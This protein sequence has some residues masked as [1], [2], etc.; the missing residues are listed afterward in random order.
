M[1]TWSSDW[2]RVII[3]VVITHQ[4]LLAVPKCHQAV[5]HSFICGAKSSPERLSFI[6]LLNSRI[7]KP[8]KTSKLQM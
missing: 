8:T 4:R 3:V 5:V 6:S 7:C 2:K 1:H